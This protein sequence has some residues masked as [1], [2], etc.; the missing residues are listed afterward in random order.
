MAKYI[1][2]RLFYAFLTLLTLVG[3]TFF[4][5]RLLLVIPS[6]GRRQSRKRP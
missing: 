6:S 2:K 1:I 4:M 3:I 5:M